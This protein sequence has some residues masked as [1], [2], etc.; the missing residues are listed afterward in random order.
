MLDD[1]RFVRFFERQWRWLLGTRHWRDQT[2]KL[3]RHVHFNQARCPEDLHFSFVFSH[4]TD[5]MVTLRE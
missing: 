1:A 4:L 5:F 2:T 3:M